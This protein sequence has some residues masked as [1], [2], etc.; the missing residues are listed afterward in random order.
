M[1]RQAG[2]DTT[3]KGIPVTTQAT[4]ICQADDVPEGG[5]LQ[6][7]LPDREP[8][9][10]FQLKGEF[11]VTDDTCTHGAASLCEGEI[12]DGL[13]FCPFHAGSFDIRSGAPVDK[14]C[15]K[16]LRTYPASTEAGAI[17]ALLA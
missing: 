7:V 11:F 3:K 6:I 4:L 1:I 12:E 5:A 8:L 15:T 16:A 14:P 9:A 13:V 10:V 17:Y 2:P